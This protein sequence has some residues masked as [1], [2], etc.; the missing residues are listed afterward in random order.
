MNSG[1]SAS[2]PSADKSTSLRPSRE[3]PATIP[4]VTHLPVASITVAP[5]GT[6][7]DGPAAAALG[8]LELE[9]DEQPAPVVAVLLDP[10]VELLDLLLVEEAQHPLLQLT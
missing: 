4:G 8:R 9:V 10:V 5:A 3:K 2:N 6:R 7:T 1:C